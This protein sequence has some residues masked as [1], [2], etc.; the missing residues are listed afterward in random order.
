MSGLIFNAATNESDDSTVEVDPGAITVTPSTAKDG[1]QRIPGRMSVS[2]DTPLTQV[3]VAESGGTP[4]VP[5]T[6]DADVRPGRSDPKFDGTRATDAVNPLAHWQDPKIPQAD[7]TTPTFTLQST[8]ADGSFTKACI[9]LSRGENLVTEIKAS[10]HVY[11]KFLDDDD[12]FSPSERLSAF[13]EQPAP[14]PFLAVSS[15]GNKVVV[16]H[17]VHKFAVPLMYSHEE[18]GE[19]LAF[20]EDNKGDNEFPVIVKMNDTDFE[21]AQVWFHPKVTSI[22]NVLDGRQVLPVPEEQESVKTS[23]IIPLLAFLVPLFMNGGKPFNTVDAYKCFRDEFLEK[24]PLPLRLRSAYITNFLLAAAGYDDSKDDEDKESQLVA[25]LK[26]LP[27]DPVLIM[28]WAST[29]YS[30]VQKQDCRYLR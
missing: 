28:Q 18:D 12:T 26:E 27:M 15:P 5:G 17:G 23:K 25:D 8:R 10:L 4:V 14:F 11:K 22:M 16:L 1:S 7:S 30:S 19:T 2:F 3:S 6:E 24:A 21:G 13:G 20:V 29:H 9:E